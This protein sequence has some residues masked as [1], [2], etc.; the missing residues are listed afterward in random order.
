ML[1]VELEQAREN[2]ERAKARSAF[3]T[4]ETGHVEPAP[5]R[6]ITREGRAMANLIHQPVVCP[7]LIG[8]SAEMT[9]LQESIEAAA[10]GQGRV[11]L[12]SGEAAIGKSR[13]VSE[14][15]REASPLSFQLLAG[16]S[17]PAH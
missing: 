16:Q 3:R 9:A 8:R 6:E 4:E 12:L 13:L 7:I 17:F 10:S 1:G 15:Q 14:L 5:L 11:V 2:F